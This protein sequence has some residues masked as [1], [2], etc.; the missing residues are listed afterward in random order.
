MV[1]AQALSEIAQA[2]AATKPDHA[3]R[4]FA[5]AERV[6]QS[7]DGQWKELAI[8]SIAEALAATDPDRAVRVAQSVAFASI[9]AQALS[10][11]AVAAWPDL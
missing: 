6:A 10:A 7:V 1:K 8:A 11:V 5:D 9:K 2:L 3:A 4:V